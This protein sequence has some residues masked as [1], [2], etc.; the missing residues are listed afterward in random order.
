M[1]VSAFIALIAAAVLLIG[2]VVARRRGHLQSRGALIAV[3]VLIG[4]LIVY[5][6]AAGLVPTK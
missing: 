2:G 4:L 6:M 1:P 3:T 5:G